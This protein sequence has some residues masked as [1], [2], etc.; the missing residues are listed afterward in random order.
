[1]A[2]V[3]ILNQTRNPFQVTNTN[4]ELVKV[5]PGEPVE[6]SEETAK[7]LLKYVGIVDMAKYTAPSTPLEA[8]DKKIAA[9]EAELAKLKAGA[10]KPAVRKDEDSLE[11]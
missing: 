6:V 3:T 9:L 1:M 4:G 2:K 8:K 7:T 11:D 5:R 10:A